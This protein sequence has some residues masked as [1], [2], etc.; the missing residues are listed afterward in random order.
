MLT[1]TKRSGAVLMFAILMMVMS[2]TAEACSHILYETGTG[3]YIVGR[4]MDWNDPT[5][6][7]RIWA[8][9]K[10]M[11]RE[12]GA[13]AN[14]IKWTSQYGSV[15]ASFYDAGTADG[16]N[17]AGLVG[18]MLYLAES[19]YGDPAKTGKP[20]IS[21]GAWLQY[22]LDKY[23]TVKEVVDAM[24]KEPFTVVAPVLPN[25]RAATVHVSLSDPTGDSAIFEYI[26]GKLVIH[27]GP[28]CRVM[29]NSPIYEQQLAL[30]AYWD[31]IG[32]N[33][34]LPGTISAAD[35]FVRLSYN[36]KSSP[37]FKDR[38]MA[39]A[40]VFSQMRAIGV[41][42]G[43]SDPAHPNI[44]STLWRAVSDHDAKRYYFE[45]TIKP[46]IFWVDLDKVD[47]K[48]GATPM[49]IDVNGPKV[50]AGEVSDEF[51]PAEPFKWLKD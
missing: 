31:L 1:T 36:L 48:A 12:G 3:T 39:V 37:K 27:H 50:L 29:T 18:N 21:I 38:T 4:S 19:D 49:M 20:T 32:G 33:N 6:K 47:L 40:A 35:R 44:S 28:E 5:A 26:G 14:P 11:E 41:P 23:A 9:P 15:V 43:M 7:T 8:F 45:S 46:A 22:L 25:G 51:E 10:G 17:E 16:M 2:Q 24:R 30:N 42:L 34:F 13:G